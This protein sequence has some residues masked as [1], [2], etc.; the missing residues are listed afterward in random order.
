MV[1]LVNV[2]ERLFCLAVTRNCIL[3]SLEPNGT[4]RTQITLMKESHEGRQIGL[5]ENTRGCLGC[6]HTLGLG[7]A[8]HLPHLGLLQVG[9]PRKD[10]ILFNLNSTCWLLVRLDIEVWLESVDADTSHLSL[11]RSP[12]YIYHILSSC[13]M[14]IPIAR[15]KYMFH[16]VL[17]A[18]RF[19]V[20][21]LRIFLRRVFLPPFFSNSFVLFAVSP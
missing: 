18:L 4:R 2:V 21:F 3:D 12:K 5:V 16:Y 19:I 9:E 1:K 17:L 10:I 6:L 15:L 13:I 20:R 14:L 8:D 7:V 11:I